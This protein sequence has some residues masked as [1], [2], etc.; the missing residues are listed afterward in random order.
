MKEEFKLITD[1]AFS[2][3]GK[4]KN[5]D[6]DVASIASVVLN[7]IAKPERFGATPEQVV[8]SPNQFSSIGGREWEKTQSGKMTQQEEKLYK[9][10]AQIVSGVIKGTIQSPAGDADHFVNL[11]L[12]KP[13]WAKVY[14]KTYDSGNHSFY[15]EVQVVKPVTNRKK[16]VSVQEVQ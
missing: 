4:N 11:K 6:N 10:A 16:R 2:E 1:L 12:A 9:R 7:R 5:F 3:A 8:F 13:S 15:K 14:P